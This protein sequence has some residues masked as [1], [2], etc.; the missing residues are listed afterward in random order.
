MTLDDI[1]DLYAEIRLAAKLADAELS[2]V[3]DETVV[4]IP[5]A[6]KINALLLKGK[7]GARYRIDGLH[8]TKEK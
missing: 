4:D 5:D 2:Q 1:F 3:G 8:L 7:G 6:K